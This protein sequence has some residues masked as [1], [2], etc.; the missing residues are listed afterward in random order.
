MFS[1]L[2]IAGMIVGLVGCSTVAGTV[3]GLGE[4]VKSGT[5]AVADWVKPT[6]GSKK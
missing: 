3:K 1:K 5:D 4:D 6:Q 2:F